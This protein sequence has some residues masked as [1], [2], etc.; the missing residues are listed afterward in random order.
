MSKFKIMLITKKDCVDFVKAVTKV[1]GKVI[2]EDGEG[3]RVNGK[4]LL[5]AALAS[6]EWDDLWVISEEDIYSLVRPWVV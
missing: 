4:S 1:N 2:L 3:F 6:V 5:G